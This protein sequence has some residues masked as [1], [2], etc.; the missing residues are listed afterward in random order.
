MVGYANGYL[1]YFPIR[2]SYDEGGY[3]VVQGAW[4]RVAP[5]RAERLEALGKRLLAQLK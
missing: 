4:S 5:G 1:G 2:R 3:E